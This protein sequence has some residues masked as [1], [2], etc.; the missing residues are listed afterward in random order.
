MLFAPDWTREDLAELEERA[1]AHLDGLR[2]AGRN[3]VD[4]ARAALAGGEPGAVTA[5]TFVML[6]TERGEFISEVLAALKTGDDAVVDAVRVG[7]RHSPVAR[8]A[9]PLRRL[10]SSG[11]GR[12]R[13]A[14]FDVLAFHRRKVPDGLEELLGDEDPAIR[15]LAWQAAGRV[16]GSLSTGHIDRALSDDAPGLGRVALEALA[17]AG[18]PELRERCLAAATDL[19]G[20]NAHALGFLGVLG[21]PADLAPLLAGLGRS[22]LEAVALEGLGALG[23]PQ[24]VPRLIECMEDE[25]LA[26]AAAAAFER[27]TGFEDVRGE[28]PAPDL[29]PGSFEAEFE[30]AE[31]GPVEPARAR[32]WWQAHGPELDPA[33]PWQAGFDVAAGVA[34]SAWDA[35]PLPVR[36]D[37]YLRGCV[38]GR[39]PGDLEIEARV[40]AGA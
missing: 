4:L 7:L 13:A 2:L 22:G 9:K 29:E 17:R 11:T 19:R 1:E 38:T 32:A 34:A 35:L 12:A 31:E 25:A 21:H 3:G 20:A 6:A 14:A 26:E 10:A 18:V 24:S 28:R 36:R 8:V 27:I 16:P 39:A 23:S 15:S 37:L 5:A 30:D 40:V 33:R